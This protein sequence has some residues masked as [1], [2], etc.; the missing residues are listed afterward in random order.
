MIACATLGAFLFSIAWTLGL[1]E[2]LEYFE[3]GTVREALYLERYG[4]K[5]VQSERELNP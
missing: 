2:V 4:A 3:I 5:A 1:Y